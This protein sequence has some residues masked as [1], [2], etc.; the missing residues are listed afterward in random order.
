MFFAVRFGN[1]ETQFS[2]QIECWDRSEAVHCFLCCSVLA[3]VLG[4]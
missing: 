1:F 4:S 3:C 2:Y